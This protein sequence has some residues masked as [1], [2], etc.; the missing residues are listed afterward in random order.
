MVELEIKPF[1]GE[2]IPGRRNEHVTHWAV[3]LV[4]Q[5]TKDLIFIR[6]FFTRKRA[7]DFIN[8][9]KGQ[10]DNGTYELSLKTNEIQFKFFKEN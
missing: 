1:T 9:V 4:N 5:L 8:E 2:K 10:I 6:S 7:E 3:F